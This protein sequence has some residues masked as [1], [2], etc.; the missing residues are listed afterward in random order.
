MSASRE[1]NG[2]SGAGSTPMHEERPSRVLALGVEDAYLDGLLRAA[3]G[4]WQIAS[5]GERTDLVLV[6]RA[7]CDA[8]EPSETLRRL[9]Q[10]WPTACVVAIEPR[11]AET[12]RGGAMLTL[13]REASADDAVA[14]AERAFRLHKL[15]TDPDLARVVGD[16]DRLPSVPQTFAAL[17]HATSSSGCSVAEVV[18]I[19]E[20]DPAMSLKILQLVNSTFFGQA[21]RVIS[22]AQAVNQL[23][24]ELLRGLAVNAQVFT[25]AFAS[26]GNTFS[27]ERFQLY[28]VRTARLARTFAQGLDLGDDPFT[29][30]IVHNIGELVLA[31]QHPG[32]YAKMRARVV[33]TGERADEVEKELLGASHAE[34][35][36]ATLWAA[37]VPFGIV[38]CVAY[39]H[40]PRRVPAG[41]RALLAAIHAVDALAGI[42]TCGEPEARLDM[43]FL[44][45][46]GL[47]GRVA[48]WRR[49]VEVEAASWE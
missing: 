6:D 21:R 3:G 39:H 47:S 8:N 2:V 7:R 43:E 34:A 29:A 38:E 37:G 32:T 24:V 4:Q 16:L 17:H 48:E 30:A 11:D 19:V 35:G 40:T 15:V 25:A 1:R 46:V 45:S 23:G 22:V 41:P 27:L 49:L 20:S 31:I 14:L 13:E 42:V 28:S 33:D 5:G 18:A 10:Q 9:E 44:E 12:P 36:A 26:A